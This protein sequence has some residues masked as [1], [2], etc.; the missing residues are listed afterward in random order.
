M[1]AGRD[2]EL[3][4][5]W[6]EEEAED[7]EAAAVVDDDVEEE[8]EEETCRPP[9]APRSFFGVDHVRGDFR[10]WDELVLTLL[11]TVISAFTVSGRVQTRMEADVVAFSGDFKST[12]QFALY[13]VILIPIAVLYQAVNAGNQPGSP[14]TWSFISASL[15][16]GAGSYQLWEAV[17]ITRSGKASAIGEASGQA[18]SYFAVTCWLLASV[19]QLSYGLSSLCGF[20]LPTKLAHAD[21]LA[22]SRQVRVKELL[23]SKHR[24]RDDDDDDDDH[25][26]RSHCQKNDDIQD[27]RPVGA[28]SSSM[29]SETSSTVVIVANPSYGITQ[30][31]DSTFEVRSLLGD[32]LDLDAIFFVVESNETK[33][34]VA[35]P[36]TTTNVSSKWIHALSAFGTKA[37][38]VPDDNADVEEGGS[39]QQP[40]DDDNNNADAQGEE[41]A[42]AVETEE[43]DAGEEMERGLQRPMSAQLQDGLEDMVHKSWLSGFLGHGKP[44]KDGES[45]DAW[46]VRAS[47]PPLIFASALGSFAT[48][49][50]LGTY[51]LSIKLTRFGRIAA[52]LRDI[53]DRYADLLTDDDANDDDARIVTQ[54]DNYAQVFETIEQDFN[55]C[56]QI[57]GWASLLITLFIAS[58]YVPLW[59]AAT[60]RAAKGHY[61]NG[62]AT[63]RPEERVAYGANLFG[64]YLSIALLAF[65]FFAFAIAVAA[66]CLINDGM[67]SFLWSFRTLALSYGISYI[68]KT[69]ILQPYLFHGYATD[70]FLIKRD[71]PFYLCNIAWIAYGVFVG[72]TVAL[73]RVALYF[74]YSVYATG[75]LGNCI[76]PEKFQQVD[77]AYMSY[78]SQIHLHNHHHNTVAHVFKDTLL[79]STKTYNHRGRNRWHL[80]YTLIHNPKLRIHRRRPSTTS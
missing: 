2:I 6:D 61:R 43:K 19:A 54:L 17:R 29:P 41:D 53:G 64:A 14:W 56:W 18:L 67:R 77:Y 9:R 58:S 76:L 74:A 80:A 35:V 49:A 26:N 39:K 75:D 7:T 38:H 30:I 27:G 51:F 73:V 60:K 16:A 46:Y 55:T 42:A 23:T 22:T 4:A 71:V 11:G 59:D 66:F 31:D 32:R 21:Q 57:G 20:T 3:S 72:A 65:V 44:T 25:E 63:P 37:T 1:A 15:C 45:W 24:L 47:R 33:P 34:A 69:Y 62:R 10:S 8:E 13:V 12:I 40:Q 50:V 48:V 78:T 70:G 52:Q 79:T 68:V 36:K 5:V 28:S